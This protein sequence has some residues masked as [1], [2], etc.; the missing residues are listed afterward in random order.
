MVT[1]GTNVS[2][3]VKTNYQF[4]YMLQIEVSTVNGL[5]S[6]QTK[7]DSTNNDSPQCTRAAILGEDGFILRRSELPVATIFM[8]CQNSYFVN[9]KNALLIN[10]HQETVVDLLKAKIESFKIKAETRGASKESLTCIP[11]YD[12]SI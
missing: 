4:D 9:K 11:F 7:V 6:L 3:Y 10:R 8:R 5:S 2:K 1:I 12:S